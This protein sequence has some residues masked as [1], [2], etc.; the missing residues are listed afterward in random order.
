MLCLWVVGLGVLW[1]LF[2]VGLL[3]FAIRHSLMLV[4]TKIVWGNCDTR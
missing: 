2:G 4:V 1:G 3:S